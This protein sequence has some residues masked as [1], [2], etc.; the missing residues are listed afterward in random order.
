MKED[1]IKKAFMESFDD[2]FKNNNPK[3]KKGEGLISK[4]ELAIFNNQKIP[5]SRRYKVEI[6]DDP[7]ISTREKLEDVLGMFIEC[8]KYDSSLHE[9]NFFYNVEIFADGGQVGAI[10]R[11]RHVK[12]WD[13]EHI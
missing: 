7:V 12:E 8:G 10:L 9:H 2:F 3:F 11:N 4:A 1:I 13:L 6:V 5:S